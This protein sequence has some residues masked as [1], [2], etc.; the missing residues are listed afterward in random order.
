MIDVHCHLN[1]KSFREDYDEV[2]KQAKDAGVEKIINV[3]TSLESSEWAVRLAQEYENLYA[4]VGIHPHHADKVQHNWI[5]KLEKTAT[6]PKVLAIGE[7]GLD[8]YSY[9]SNGI[10][11]PGLQKEVFISQ[12]KLAHRLKLPLQIHNRHAGEDVIKVLNEH[13]DFLQ[14]KPGMFHCFAATD[15]VLKSALQMGFCIGFDGNITYPGLAPGETVTLSQLAKDTPLD[16]I[17]VETDS[18]YLTPMPHRGERNE[19]KYAIIT[20]EYIADLK[21]VRYTEFEEQIDKNAY[22]IFPKLK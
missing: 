20:A 8:Y 21:G 14:E 12:I 16:R 17:L 3:G 18:P 2:I 19:P 10:V 5:E 1:F 15:E 7:I 13:K 6:N 9:K 22:T 4:I 11:D